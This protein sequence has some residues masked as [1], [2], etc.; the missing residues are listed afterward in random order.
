MGFYA[1]KFLPFLGLESRPWELR[2]VVT[3]IDPELFPQM[4]TVFLAEKVN[5]RNLEHVASEVR[6]PFYD[7]PVSRVYSYS[8]FSVGHSRRRP[9]SPLVLSGTRI[10]LRE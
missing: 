9:G 2:Y 8:S 7:A 4:V 10:S 1:K 6:V 5:N 3:F